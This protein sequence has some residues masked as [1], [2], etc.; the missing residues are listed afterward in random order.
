MSRRVAVS[1]GLVVI[2]ALAVVSCGGDDSSASKPAVNI[3]TQSFGESTITGQLYGQLLKAHG[4]HVNYQSIQDEASIYS[5][6]GSGDVNFVPDYAQKALGQ[7]N[8]NAGDTSGDLSSTLTRLDEQLKAKKLKAL[9]PS[10]A[11]DGNALVVT[12][13]TA[14]KYHL[15]NISDL[16][17]TMKL[18]GPQDCPT[19]S[20]CIPPIKSAYGLDLAKHFV[21]LDSG[22]PETK[23]ALQ[24]GDID[25]AVLFSTD[26]AI[27][28]NGWVELKDDKGIF[29]NSIVPVVANDLASN[30]EV[31]KLANEVSAKLTTEN[32]TAMNKQF[33]VDKED[34]ATIAK[35]F[36]T[37][38]GLL[39]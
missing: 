9:E 12:K 31:V 25:V 6:L 26:P 21:P 35:G 32:V 11:V 3:A 33:D 22:G 20:S 17:A 14:E 13:E 4:F 15:K 23:K 29:A 18:G 10:K 36:L 27:A 16:K 37:K 34:A 1:L 38:N 39:S 30:A 2:A 24:N 19:N 8:S 28:S 7:L 5:A